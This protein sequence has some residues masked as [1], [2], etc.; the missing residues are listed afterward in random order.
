VPDTIV[1]RVAQHDPSDDTQWIVAFMIG[2]RHLCT[3]LPARPMVVTGPSC[4]NLARQ[5]G[6]ASQS[7]DQLASGPGSV[8]SPNASA[9]VLQHQ[10]GERA[11]HLVVGGSWHHLVPIRPDIVSAATEHDLLEA[12]RVAEAWGAQLGWTLQGDTY[13]RIDPYLL[14]GRVRDLLPEPAA[15]ASAGDLIAPFV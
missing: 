2:V 9:N 4:A 10:A 13:V 12:L 7:G 8:A 6:L 5:L 3:G 1:Q 14:A 15:P 11:V